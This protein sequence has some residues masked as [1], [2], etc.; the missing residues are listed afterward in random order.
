MLESSGFHT[1]VDLDKLLDVARGL[2]Q[3]LQHDVPSQ[4]LK[5]GKRTDLHASGP[6]QS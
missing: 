6:T 3:L 1:G 4:V 2:P 5:A